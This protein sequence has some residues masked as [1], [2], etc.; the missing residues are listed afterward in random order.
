M[1][2]IKELYINLINSGITPDGLTVDE[3]VAI[4]KQKENEEE[5]E[6]SRLQSGKQED[7]RKT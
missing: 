7:S 1:G 2:K 6:Y 3:A 5:A 4:L